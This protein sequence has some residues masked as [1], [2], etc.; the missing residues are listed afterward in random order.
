MVR[1]WIYN[2]K[3]KHVTKIENRLK[4]LEKFAKEITQ[5]MENWGPEVQKKRDERDQRWDEMVRVLTI[6]DRHRD[7]K[8]NE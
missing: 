3:D 4:K 7:K 6:Q 8:D 2:M 5:Y 1:S